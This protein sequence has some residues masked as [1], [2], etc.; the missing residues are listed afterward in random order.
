VGTTHTALLHLRS[1]PEPARE[2]L[3]QSW[4]KVWARGLL[5]VFGVQQHLV[6]PPPP[7][8]GRARLVV[9]NHRSPIDIILMLQH[10]GG[11]VLSHHGVEQWPILG[12]AASHAGTIFVDRDDRRSGVKAIREIRRRLQQGRTVI[13]FPEGTTF[14]G[15]EVRPFMGGAFAAVR[16]I[17]AEVVPVG[18]AYDPGAEFW[19]ETFME[20]VTRVSRRARTR[21]GL[22]VGQ[23]QPAEE[24]RETL[25]QGLRD[26][27]QVL[28]EQA[29]RRLP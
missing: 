6:G 1:R 4:I 15:D 18:I 2:E 21:V 22:A 16:G 17:D 13:V 10:F 5:G 12:A 24:D 8:G 19:Q 9:A 25:A 7:P 26:E 28:V 3:L 14:R 27:V 11:C 29:R 20:H 23:P